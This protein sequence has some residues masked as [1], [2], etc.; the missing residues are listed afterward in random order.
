MNSSNTA[1]PSN[2]RSDISRNGGATDSFYT[3]T[4]NYLSNDAESIKPQRSDIMQSTSLN[5]G[6][7]DYY[8][9]TRD[10]LNRETDSTQVRPQSHYSPFHGQ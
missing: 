1:S 8:I 2:T 4:R 9:K 5:D 10:Y 3:K 6:D 7:T